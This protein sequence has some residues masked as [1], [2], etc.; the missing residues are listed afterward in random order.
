MGWIREQSYAE[1][2]FDDVVVDVLSGSVFAGEIGLIHGTGGL[3]DFEI[4]KDTGGE[5]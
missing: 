3:A 4:H 5:A 2:L 1:H